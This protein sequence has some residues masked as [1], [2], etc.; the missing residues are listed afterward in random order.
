MCMQIEQLQQTLREAVSR[1]SHTKLSAQVA[2]LLSEREE[3]SILNQQ[4]KGQL[5]PA[6]VLPYVCH[7]AHFAQVV[8][9]AR[10]VQHQS[11]L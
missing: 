10:C 6:F 5:V 8:A 11:Q 9:L 7:C 3:L 2:E 4:L 1:S